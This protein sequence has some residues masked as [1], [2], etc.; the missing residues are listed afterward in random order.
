MTELCFSKDLGEAEE[1]TFTR[2]EVRMGAKKSRLQGSR[3]RDI[4]GPSALELF[5]ATTLPHFT[6]AGISN[7]Y[8]GSSQL[9]F[10]EQSHTC[11]EAHLRL[12]Y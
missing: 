3:P 7:T 4:I 1:L 2:F 12:P 8:T 5:E 11:H 10:Q 9:S 6:I